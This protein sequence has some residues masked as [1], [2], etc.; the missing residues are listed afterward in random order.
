MLKVR[1]LIMKKK[2]I[3]RMKMKMIQVFSSAHQ[4][5]MS[6]SNRIGL[7]TRK[8]SLEGESSD[9]VLALVAS[10][11]EHLGMVVTRQ[12]AGLSLQDCIVYL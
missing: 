3:S 6:S 2:V 9:T 11:S 10:A 5:S 8:N 12:P 1:K 7:P 4:G